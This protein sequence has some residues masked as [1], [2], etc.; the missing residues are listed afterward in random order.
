MKYTLI[1][2]AMLA[3]LP[4]A[5]NATVLVDYDMSPASGTSLAAST[6][7]T[8]VSASDLAL[9]NADNGAS[10]FDNHF[11]HTGWDT[12]FNSGK[13]YE[14]TMG[15][16][17]SAYDLDTMSFSLEEIGGTASTYWLRSSLDGFAVDLATGGFSGGLVTDFAVDLSVLGQMVG[18]ISFRFYMTGSDTGERAG[19][20]NHHCP[21]SGCGMADVGLDLTITGDIV[22]EPG[23]L[24]LFGFGLIGMGAVARRRRS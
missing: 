23:M 22:P 2:G 19:F 15:A 10:A 20:A 18:P 7:A 1:A 12:T 5:A 17:G 13:Y 6:V 8:G 11:Y 4:M 16:G 14:M 9:T 21:G 3:A 24:G